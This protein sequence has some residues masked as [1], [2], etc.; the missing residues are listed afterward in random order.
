M[1]N[2]CFGLNHVGIFTPDL[3]ASEEFYRD[4]FGFK[5]VFH[6][7][8]GEDGEFDITV[9]QRD[10]LQIELLRLAREDRDVEQEAYQ[11]LNH[12]AINCTDTKALV[13][14]LRE[15]GIHFETESDEYVKSFGTPPRDLDIIFFHGPGGERI[16]I[17]Q[18]IWNGNA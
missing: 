12:F 3:R 4:I 7:D 16:E 5:K 13:R 8:A 18:E 2:L 14:V 10:G 11:T 9:M 6:V 1:S 15:K 17:Y